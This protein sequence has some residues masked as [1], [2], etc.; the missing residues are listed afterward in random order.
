MNVTHRLECIMLIDDDEA[1][2]Y[3]HHLVIE[4]SGV[5]HKI[6]VFEKPEQALDYFLTPN[7]S[8]VK[9]DLLLLDLNM[10]RMNGW[11]F[12]DEFDTLPNDKKEGITILILSTSLNPYDVE[13]ATENKYVSGFY[14]KPLD[15]LILEEI[16]SNHF[17]GIL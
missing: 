5:A 9:P 6:I 12:L 11:E 8:H 4:R 10:P 14:N 2:N 16:V 7:G 13:K 3:L 1:T 17:P 15:S